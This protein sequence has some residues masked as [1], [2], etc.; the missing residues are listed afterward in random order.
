MRVKVQ[1]EVI[2]VD[3]NLDDRFLLERWLRKKKVPGR[4]TAFASAEE[5]QDYLECSA[6]AGQNGI[7]ALILLSVTLFD[8]S[9]LELLRWIR[10]QTRFNGTLILA[11]GAS[12]LEADV[13]L[14]YDLGVNGYFT[15]Q[16]DFENLSEVLA[17]LE[18]VPTETGQ[19]AG[20]R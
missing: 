18:F 12:P 9:G 17:G 20:N 3:D 6:R 15:K 8:N 7:P 16:V 11:L 2:L 13:Q 10:N 1:G 4:I 19:C 5:A 14:A